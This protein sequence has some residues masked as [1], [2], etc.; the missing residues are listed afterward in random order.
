MKRFVVAMFVAI[1]LAGCGGDAAKVEDLEKSNADLKTRVES[2]E[3]NL[4]DAQKQL[5]QQ[6][7]AMQVLNTRQRE[8]ENYFNKLQAGQTR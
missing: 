3:K 4:L 5:I 1:V 2:L 7:Q 8:M 6:Q